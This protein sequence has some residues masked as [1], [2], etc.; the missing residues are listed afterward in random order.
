M[1]ELQNQVKH[2]RHELQQRS[3]NVQ[4]ENSE[5]DDDKGPS[6]GAVGGNGSVSKQDQDVEILKETPNEVLQSNPGPSNK[7]KTKIDSSYLEGSHDVVKP[8]PL[9]SLM[10]TNEST[11]AHEN[12]KE[13]M[14]D[15]ERKRREEL[16]QRL[17]ALRS[18]VPIVS[19]VSNK[20]LIN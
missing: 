20:V 18:I 13:S 10:M 9:K 16:T 4:S 19:G 2:L 14:L 15:A 1:E 3:E 5:H 12:V 11:I 7:N 6:T 8:L 17:Y